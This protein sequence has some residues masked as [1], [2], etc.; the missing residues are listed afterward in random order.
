MWTK[1]L[2]HFNKEGK[3]RIESATSLKEFTDIV[4]MARLSEETQLRNV[5]RIELLF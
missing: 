4:D 3:W 5:R 2:M 1:S